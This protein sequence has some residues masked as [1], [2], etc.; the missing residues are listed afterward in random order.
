MAALTLCIVFS[1]AP[2]EIYEIQVQQQ[3]QRCLL[4]SAAKT[5]WTLGLSGRRGVPG[6]GARSLAQHDLRAR[7]LSGRDVSEPAARSVAPAESPAHAGPPVA[8][9]R[10]FLG[11]VWPGYQSFKATS[12]GSTDL[13][14]E[15]LMYW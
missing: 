13:L 10:I 2:N 15:W 4:Q 1:E 12:L 8:P 6:M 3:Q 9:C 5:I 7:H 14:Q 11:Y